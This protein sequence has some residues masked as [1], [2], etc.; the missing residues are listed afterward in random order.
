MEERPVC[1]GLSIG[2]EGAKVMTGTQK[3]SL[4]NLK[5][6]DYMWAMSAMILGLSLYSFYLRDLLASLALFSVAF[7]FL[8][9][10]L[11]AVSLVWC[12]SVQVAIWTRSAPRNVIALSRRLIAPYAKP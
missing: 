10:A 8:V 2:P 4:I 9:L 1:C 7:F 5:A 3:D 11:L 6:P 12:A